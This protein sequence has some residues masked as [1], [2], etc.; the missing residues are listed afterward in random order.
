LTVVALAGR[1]IDPPGAQPARFPL[2]RESQVRLRIRELFEQVSPGWLVSS[3]ACGA[4]LIAQEVAGELGIERWVVLPFDRDQF[5][6]HSVV[7]RPGD[8]G[9]RFDRLMDEL[10][11]QDT[12]I[13]LH[14]QPGA[15]DVYA[16]A[17]QAILDKASRLAGGSN[18][19]VTAAIVWEGESRGSGDNTAAFADAARL[20]GM[21]V[22]PVLTT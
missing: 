12:I 5:R 17:N 18:T 14:L 19:D 4:D 3:A 16:Q 7:D 20:R 13:N 9:P 21:T 2:E 1:R 10:E 6:T 15:K 22:R 11:H 8:W